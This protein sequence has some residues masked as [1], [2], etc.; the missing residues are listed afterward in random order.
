MRIRAALRA[1][2]SV[3]ALSIACSQGAGAWPHLFSSREDE[4]IKSPLPPTYK[5]ISL[6]FE[7]RVDDLISR[8][9]LEE[10][11]SQ[12]VNASRPIPRLGIP[13]YNWWNE[14]LH[15][16]ARNGG[17]TVFPQAI[18][19]G[20]T[21]D[22]ALIPDAIEELL[23]LT[24]PVQGLARTTTRDV[25][26]DGTTIPAGRRVMLLYAAANR[27]PRVYGADAAC[28]YHYKISA[29]AVGRQ[30]V[31][32]LSA[33]HGPRHAGR[34]LPARHRQHAGVRT[35]RRHP[36]G[37]RLRLRRPLLRDPLSRATDAPRPG[38]GLEC[39]RPSAASCR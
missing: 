6:P 30:R 24:S 2:M 12:L 35:R 27:D 22:P 32:G 36:V 10:K 9:T 5:D 13:G 26:I 16:V 8:M 38:S 20:A 14:A 31:G 19:L 37:Q 15:G 1:T 39:A 21:F 18:A 11:A 25:E 17:A 29:R 4:D 23:R 33:G 7:Q 3:V 28:R 34:Q